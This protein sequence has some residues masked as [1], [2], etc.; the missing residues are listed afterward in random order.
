MNIG[1][2][3]LGAEVLATS[4][5]RTAD[6]GIEILDFQF[7][8]INYVEAVRTEVYN[9]MISERKRIAEQ[10]RSQGTGEAARING[11]QEQELATITSEAF[12]QAEEI[13]GTADAE[14]ANIY[15]EAYNKNP[16][17]YGFLRSLETYEKILD[18]ETT[19]ILS[20]IHI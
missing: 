9:R 6:L 5:T 11:Q 20:L 10:F 18:D 15:A 16:E 3:K 12:R 17:L 2:E 13:R 4:Q 19:V 7:K 1:R 8:R 14:A